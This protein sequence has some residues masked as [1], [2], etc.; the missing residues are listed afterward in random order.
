MSTEIQEA[1]EALTRKLMGLPGISGTAI[2]L[3]DGKPCLMVYVAD[4]AAG[5]AVPSTFQGF[6]VVTEVTGS[7]RRV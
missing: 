5:R 2:G 3:N 4:R 6:R 1:H 7:F